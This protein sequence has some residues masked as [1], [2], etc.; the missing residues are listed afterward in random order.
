MLADLKKVL[1]GVETEETKSQ[2]REAR[3]LIRAAVTLRQKRFQI[4]QEAQDD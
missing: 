2:A 3:T 1:G 4:R